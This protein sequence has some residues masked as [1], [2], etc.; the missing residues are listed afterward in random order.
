[1]YYTPDIFACWIEVIGILSALYIIASLAWKVWSILSLYVYGESN[2]DYKA[3]GDWSVV[4]GS[5]DGIGLQFAEQLAAKGQNIVLISRSLEKLERV[6]RNIEEKYGVST[7]VIAAD[8]SAADIYD[9]IQ[10]GIEGLKV[11]TLI[12]NVGVAYDHPETFH[13][14][15]E[16]WPNF[17]EKMVMVNIMSVVKM[18]EMILPKMVAQKKGLIL[19][20]SS[21]SGLKPLPTLA[22]YGASKQF[23]DSFSKAVATECKSEGVVVQSVMPFFVSTKMAKF[24]TS[25]LVPSPESYVRDCLRT[26]GRTN[27]TFGCLSHALQAEGTIMNNEKL[28]LAM[29]LKIGNRLKTRRLKKLAASKEK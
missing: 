13:Q 15:V 10:S 11:G 18:T 27:R 23:V 24:N 1:M 22:L 14:G 9:R 4:T 21:G 17:A 16:R 5:T 20:I 29:W 6:S 3:L 19:N 12:N 7:K 28:H 8:Y 2:I 26:A 25:A